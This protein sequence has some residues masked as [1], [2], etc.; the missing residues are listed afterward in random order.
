MVRGQ[1]V[2]SRGPQKTLR[3]FGAAAM[4]AGAGRAEVGTVQLCGPNGCCGEWLR[5]SCGGVALGCFSLLHLIR[6]SASAGNRSLGVLCV[7][8]YSP[9][10]WGC[11][12][13]ATGGSSVPTS[14]AQG[15]LL[16]PQEEEQRS[17]LQQ[18]EEMQHRRERG[19]SETMAS[20]PR[21]EPRLQLGVAAP[22]GTQCAG[23]RGGGC[24]YGVLAPVDLGMG[25]MWGHSK[26]HK[27]QAHERA[28]HSAFR[29]CPLPELFPYTKIPGCRL[30]GCIIGSKKGWETLNLAR[31]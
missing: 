27:A 26:C 3:G 5:H 7:P 31:P 29:L 21:A 25:L 20:G 30:K 24:W 12:H 13:G 23:A 10:N 4:S 17:F 22:A 28:A 18:R 16:Q 9:R 6:A 15:P 19:N 14:P 2:P 8:S 11:Q 1:C